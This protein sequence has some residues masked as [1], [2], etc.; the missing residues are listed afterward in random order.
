M[1]KAFTLLFFALFVQA[2]YT[3]TL[4]PSTIGQVFNYSVGDSFEYSY[5][6]YGWIT[7]GPVYF[8]CDGYQLMTINSAWVR[9]NTLGFGQTIVSQDTF[10]HLVCIHYGIIDY[11]QTYFMDSF[12]V[13]SPD[14][15]IFSMYERNCS[16]PMP[17]CGDSVFI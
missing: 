3:Q 4:T 11:T 8:E 9:G 7:A 6:D 1:K 2:A 16:N 12:N 5:S 17:P 15:S 14:S 13:S 10:G